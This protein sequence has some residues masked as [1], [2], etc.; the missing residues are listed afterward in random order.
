MGMFWRKGTAAFGVFGLWVL[1]GGVATPPTVVAQAPKAEFK[2]K[3][4]GI[5]RT[6]D[7]WKLYQEWAQTVEKRTNGRV[8]FELTSL[9][10]LGLG[11]GRN[12]P[13][14]EN[15]RGGHHRDVRRVRGRRASPRR[16]PRAA[17]H[18]P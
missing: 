14:A 12:P 11:G 9:P 2:L 17:R 3:L 13:G 5:N 8:Q 6:L 7:P 10:E 1:L 18:L 4:M 16:D 15:G